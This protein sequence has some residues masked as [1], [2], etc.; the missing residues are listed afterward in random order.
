MV[1]YDAQIETMGSR[2][3][4]ETGYD[5]QIIKT[6]KGFTI[7]EVLFD[8]AE[9]LGGNFLLPCESMTSVYPFDNEW[10]HERIKE[11][12]SDVTWKFQDLLKALKVKAQHGKA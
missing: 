8:I 11:E 1:V 5:Y 3:D 10:S 4:E 12:T 7:K 6:F 2:T 9:Q